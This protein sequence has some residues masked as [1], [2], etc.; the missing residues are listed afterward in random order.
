MASDAPDYCNNRNVHS[1]YH[2][3]AQL[4]NQ[5]RVVKENEKIQILSHDGD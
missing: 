1:C 2:K 3:R 4:K 5:N